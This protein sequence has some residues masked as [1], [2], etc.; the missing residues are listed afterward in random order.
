[1]TSALTGFFLRA[2]VPMIAPPVTA[3]APEPEPVVVSLFAAPAATPLPPSEAQ[4]VLTP[5]VQVVGGSACGIGGGCAGTVAALLPAYFLLAADSGD[6][7]TGMFMLGAAAGYS[8]SVGWAIRSAGDDLGGCRGSI[9]LASLGTGAALTLTAAAFNTGLLPITPATVALGLAAP[10]I[11]GIL[12]FEWTRT[13]PCVRKP[14]GD[15]AA[16]TALI[17]VAAG[18]VYLYSSGAQLEPA[19]SLRVLAPLLRVRW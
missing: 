17:A 1:M 3:P 10:P 15:A 8:W 2:F 4:R 18:G 19:G 13:G 12:A 6:A 16:L 5:I 7:G 14:V 9:L 11:G